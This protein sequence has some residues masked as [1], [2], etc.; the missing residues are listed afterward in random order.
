[1]SKPILPYLLM[2]LP[3]AVAAA[4]A[5]DTSSA[6]K[7]GPDHKFMMDAAAD[8]MAEVELARMASGKATRS[9][10]KD[11]ARMLEDDH[12][13]ANAELTSLASQKNVS[14]PAAPR[15]AHKALKAKLEGLSGAAFDNAYVGEMVKDHEK[16][17]RLFRTEATS[18]KDA[19]VKAW[20]AK[21]L[22]VL[23]THLAKARELSRSAAPS[24]RR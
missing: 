12:G 20:A 11:Y 21:T 24:A 4:S 9:D 19:E 18:G 17:V 14:L 1:M 23:E 16:A 5:A 8:G 10:V 2:I 7:A 15:P 13:K 3:V 6:A 22:P